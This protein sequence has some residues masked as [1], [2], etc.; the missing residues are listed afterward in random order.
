MLDEG[1]KKAVHELSPHDELLVTFAAVLMQCNQYSSAI[2]VLEET[3][4]EVC[5]SLLTHATA[6]RY[7]ALIMIKEADSSSYYDAKR[8]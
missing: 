2:K 6:Y 4:L 1:Q 7:L 5:T 3:A 8:Y